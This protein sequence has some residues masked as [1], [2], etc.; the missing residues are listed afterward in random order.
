MAVVILEK[1]KNIP[2]SL[3]L[4]RGS[5]SFSTGAQG[6]VYL[7]KVPEVILINLIKVVASSLLRYTDDTLVIIV[8]I[9]Y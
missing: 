6:N 3:P 9:P 1:E 7:D 8:V 2:M 5:T 4:P